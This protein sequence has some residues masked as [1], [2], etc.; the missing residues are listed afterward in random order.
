MTSLDPKRL[1]EDRDAGKKY[2]GYCNYL[3]ADLVRQFTGS[4]RSEFESSIS[5]QNYP[6]TYY[7]S[8]KP[9]LYTGRPNCLVRPKLSRSQWDQAIG[10]EG[11]NRDT[12]IEARGHQTMGL[13][14]DDGFWGFGFVKVGITNKTSESWTPLQGDF[15]ERG[16]SIFLMRI[17][18]EDMIVLPR[19]KSNLPRLCGHFFDVD[20]DDLQQDPQYDQAVVA[21]V[22][23]STYDHEKNATTFD[24]PR[25]D[26]QRKCA[27]LAELY[28]P[29]QNMIVTMTDA[30]EPLILRAEPF[31][32]MPNPWGPL[33]Q[34]CLVLV[35][36][37]PIGMSPLQAY[38]KK[39]QELVMQGRGLAISAENYKRFGVYRLMEKDDGEKALNVKHGQM[40][41]FSDPT[42]V[43]TK[44]IGGTSEGQVSFY[45]FVKEELETDLALSQSTQGVPSD[46][47]ATAVDDAA[48]GTSIRT[49]AMRVNVAEFVGKCYEQVAWYLHNDS[50]I[51]PRAITIK[52]RRSNKAYEATFVPGPW[53]G[54]FV[55]HPESMGGGFQYIPPEEQVPFSNFAFEVDVRS[56]T[57]TDDAVEQ[58]RADDEIILL[59]GLREALAQD[60]GRKFKWT[61][62]LDRRGD[63]FNTPEWS[64]LMTEPI[65][66]AI[67]PMTGLPVQPGM[68]GPPGMPPQGMPPGA[69][70][71]PG[72]SPNVGGVDQASMIKNATIGAR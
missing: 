54:G 46:V 72:Q 15:G 14:I 22:I 16:N 39:Y 9:R 26:S 42:S 43:D 58:K 37:D 24:T 3:R 55:S 49:L 17:P 62:I 63:A 65:M 71:A 53:E 28:I 51:P 34:C 19:P 48:A 29:D 36:G 59:T 1:A 41:G 10:L 33:V 27:R 25:G 38:W 11:I 67:D 2:V 56:L 8:I 12:M 18:P 30:N 32:G 64:E 47:T 68:A 61:E 66:P 13:S 50:S 35:A 4:Q 70:P 6:F 23:A 57:F 31:W 60:S 7:T 52:D 45:E 20:L 5:P 44:E 40:Q 21:Q 69:A